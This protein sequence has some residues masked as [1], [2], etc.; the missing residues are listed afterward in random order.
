MALDLSDYENKARE[1]I[2]AFWQTRASA[3]L[4]QKESGKADQGERAGVTGGKNMDGFASSTAQPPSSPRR[5]RR[6]SMV[7][8]LSFR[9]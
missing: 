4:K 2:K 8:T 5:A 1:A 6:L 7:P 9:P 3:T